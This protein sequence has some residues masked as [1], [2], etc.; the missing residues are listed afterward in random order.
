VTDI[1]K[2]SEPRHPWSPTAI[3]LTTLLLSPIPGGILHALNYARLGHP[4]RGRL[5]LFANLGAAAA[6]VFIV[7]VLMTAPMTRWAAAILL[8]AYFY[9]SQEST[10]QA[11]RSKGGQA[12][13]I[14]VP[15]AVTLGFFLLL[16]IGLF[17]MYRAA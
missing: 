9:K 16:L 3:A 13:S 11:Y 6:V 12:A 17:M 7:P 2:P 15:V 4:E 5:A 14:W 8:A 10:F 1:A